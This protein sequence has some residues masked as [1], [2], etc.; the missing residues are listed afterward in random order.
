M[1]KIKDF[2][3]L[4]NQLQCSPGENLKAILEW[5]KKDQLVTFFSWKMF[6]IDNPVFDTTEANRFIDKEKVFVETLI[7]LKI[8]FTYIKLIPD[9]LPKIFYNRDL[10]SQTQ[11]FSKQVKRYFQKIYPGTQ[12]IRITQILGQN[13][14]LKK[15]YNLVFRRS[16]KSAINPEKLQKEVVI[17]QD[18]KIA[19][20][21]FGLFAAE[22]AVIL[23][24]F[25]NP[26]L[27]AGKRS[28]DT[29]KYEFFKF[30]PNRPV[31]PKLFVI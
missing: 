5:V 4:V 2:S 29:Y 10:D 19:L 16:L 7:D 8:G 12:V 26:I 30:P 20:K 9:E 24:Y 21:A 11:E 1:N 27:L 18:R 14:Q 3:K 6:K 25:Q 31:L 23:K 13:P 28:I 15:T 17:R 22:T